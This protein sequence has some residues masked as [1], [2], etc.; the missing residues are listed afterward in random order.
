M[1]HPIELM[2]YL[3]TLNDSYLERCTAKRGFRNAKDLEKRSY[4]K[5]DT[6]E[7]VK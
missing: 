1:D 3:K 2:K 7:N 5:G 6:E 4:D